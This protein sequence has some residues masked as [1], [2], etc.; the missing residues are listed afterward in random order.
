MYKAWK[1]LPISPLNPSF[2]CHQPN[3]SLPEDPKTPEEMFG[4]RLLLWPPKSREKVVS[5]ETDNLYDVNSSS[6]RWQE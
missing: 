6:Q 4:G 1:L 5:F 2:R 3:Y